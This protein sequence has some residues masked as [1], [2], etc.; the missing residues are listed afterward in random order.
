MKNATQVLRNALKGP[1]PL[2]AAEAAR[3]IG[4]W[5]GH[6]LIPDLIE[7]ARNHRFYSKVTAFYALAKLSATEA[8]PHLAKLVDDPNV[9]NDWYWHGAKGVRAAA[10]VSLLQLGSEAGVAHLRELAEKRENVFYRWFA[11]ALLRL[12]NAVPL[13]AY[14]TLENLCPSDRQKKYD[15]PEFSEPGMLCMLCEAL[16][17]V[18]DPAAVER[19]EF[20]LDHYS[21]FVRRQVY[22]ALYL[23][24]SS[25]ATAQ[26]ISANARKHGTDFDLIVA[27]GISKDS[28]TLAD[29]AHRAPESFDRASAID[30]LAAISSPALEETGPRGLEDADVYVRQCSVE[31]LGRVQGAA[32]QKLFAGLTEREK[33]GRVLCA[34]AATQLKGTAC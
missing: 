32:A 19:L 12:K 34:I 28:A 14:L 8:I 30:T 17:L 13:H 4:E 6:A 9:S 5:E 33:E 24:N 22:R 20:Y 26:K 29:I 7:H 25:D 15:G 23:R 10:A 21:R 18:D 3:L 16:G 2:I 31:A 11:P 27:A 1:D